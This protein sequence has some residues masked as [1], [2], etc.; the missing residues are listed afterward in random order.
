MARPSQFC[1]F[2]QLTRQYMR[3]SPL[4]IISPMYWQSGPPAWGKS[5]IFK[6][7]QKANRVRAMWVLGMGGILCNRT[8][9]MTE[10]AHFWMSLNDIVSQKRSMC[11][12]SDLVGWTQII[13]GAGYPAN[14]HVMCQQQIKLNCTW[15]P[16]G[17]LTYSPMPSFQHSESN[18]ST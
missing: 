11:I 10:K 16:I 14:N 7:F 12:L 18:I 17:C 13:E 6:A 3:T 8:D 9:A 2:W 15:E 1:D 5:Q 4:K